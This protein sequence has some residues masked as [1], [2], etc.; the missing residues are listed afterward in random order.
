ME[1]MTVSEARQEVG[2]WLEQGQYLM[3]L[4]PGLLEENDRLRMDKDTAMKD[5]ERLQNEAGDLR[6]ENQS[7]RDE[8][9]EVGETVGRLM[10][11]ILQ[12][13]TEVVQKLRPAQRRSSSE[14]DEYANSPWV[15]R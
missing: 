2:T 11:E 12:L 14:R 10:N 8:N 4:L 15:R 3:G 9:A 13:T 1:R 6:K 7:L 5:V